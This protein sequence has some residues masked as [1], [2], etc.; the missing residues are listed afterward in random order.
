MR[1]C[2]WLRLVNKPSPVS[3]ET[4]VWATP[5]YRAPLCHRDTAIGPVCSA[6]YCWTIASVLRITALSGCQGTE[7]LSAEGRKV[8]SNSPRKKSEVVQTF[9]PPSLLESVSEF[10]KDISL[11]KTSGL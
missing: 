2:D 4:S 10:C 11:K 7:N 5:N 1:D 9:S 6:Y 8:Y 3:R